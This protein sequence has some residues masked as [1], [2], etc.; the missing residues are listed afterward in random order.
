MKIND[1]D[2]DEEEDKRWLP[3]GHVHIYMWST[4]CRHVGCHVS[5]L[6]RGLPL[7]HLKKYISCH[8]LVWIKN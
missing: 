3:H 4:N 8:L 2:D 5:F 6:T 7:R 1:D